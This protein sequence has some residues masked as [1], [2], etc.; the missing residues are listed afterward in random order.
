VKWNFLWHASN[1][2]HPSSIRKVKS[3]LALPCLA[4]PVLSPFTPLFTPSHRFPAF[5]AFHA[6]LCCCCFYCCWPSA[7]KW[8]DFGL[9]LLAQYFVL[10]HQLLTV[11]G[12]I[13]TYAM[14]FSAQ[15][16]LFAPYS[17]PAGTSFALC[18]FLANMECSLWPQFDVA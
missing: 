9:L 11:P 3:F 12:S 7:N 18:K 13:K 15:T 4:L 2:C 8:K 14:E 16:N 1:A 17:I 5:S 10:M 6:L